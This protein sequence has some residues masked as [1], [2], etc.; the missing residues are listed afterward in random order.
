M[1]TVTSVVA[2]ETAL[3]PILFT[4]VR[5]PDPGGAQAYGLVSGGGVSTGVVVNGGVGYTSAPTVSILGDGVGAKAVAAI[6]A[7]AVTSVTIT[8]TGTGYTWCLIV[9]G[10]VLRLATHPF[11]TAEGG[12]QYGGYDWLG[13][14]MS[15]DIDA[16]QAMEENGIDRVP[17]V[18]LHLIDPDKYIWTNYE[19]N[20]SRGFKGAELQMDLAFFDRQ[21]ST[22]TTDYVTKFVGLCEPPEADTS[23]M[24]LVAATRNNTQQTFLPPVRISSRCPW[25]FPGD[26]ASQID[27]TNV[28]S[29]FYRCGYNPTGGSGTA[30][31]SDC[32]YTKT[33]CQSRGMF[34]I[35]RFGGITFAP[36]Q[37][38][39]GKSFLEGKY[40]EGVNSINDAKWSEPY[41]LLYG[42]TWVQPPVMNVLGDANSTR[43]EVVLCADQL[44][45]SGTTDPGSV[46]KVIVND[47]QIPFV[48]YSPDKNTFRW[49][50]VTNGKRNGSPCADKLYDSKGDPYGSLATIE[51]CVPRSLADSSSAPKVDVL[52]QGPQIHKFQGISSI[53]V[54]GGVGVATLVGTNLD[55]ASTDPTYTITISGNSNSALNGTWP[56]LNA[57]TSTTF[58]FTTTASNG[59]SSGG[60]VRYRIETDNPAWILADVLIKT[61][62]SWDEIDLQSFIDAAAIADTQINYLDSTGTPTNLD[63]DG[64]AHKRFRYSFSLRDRTSAAEVIR[65]IRAGFNAYLSWNNGRI[66][67]DIERSLGEQ[68]PAAI[69][70]SNNAS[71]ITSIAYDGSSKN[72]YSAYDFGPSSIKRDDQGNS[73]LRV[74]RSQSA[75]SP[76]KISFSFMDKENLWQQD[77][78]NEVE[79]DDVTRTTVEYEQTLNVRG[80]NT[81]DHCQRIAA[82]Y[83][84]KVHRGNPA[85][86]TRGTISVSFDTTFRAQHLRVGHIIR[87]TDAQHG[88]SNQMFRVRKISAT[89]NFE[90]MTIEASWHYDGWYQDAYGQVAQETL[91]SLRLDLTDRAPLVW[92]PNQTTPPANDPLYS[93]TERTFALAAVATEKDAAGNPVV[94]LSIVGKAPV[95]SFGTSRPPN[96]SNQATVASTGG[97]LTGNRSY[98]LAV[99]SVDSAGAYSAPSFLTRGDAVGAGSAF[100]QTVQLRTWDANAVSGVLFAGVDPRRMSWQADLTGTPSSATLTSLNDAYSGMPDL[101]A[102]KLRVKIR[103]VIH[104]G[105]FGAALTG[106]GN[107]TFTIAGAGWTT[108]QWAGYSCSVLG[109][110]AGG[111][112][113]VL[114]YSVVSNTATTLTLNRNPLTD[115]VAVGDVLCM[116]SKISVSGNTFSDANW[117]NSF[118]TGG[119]T[120]NA[121]VGNHYTVISGTGRGQSRLIT[122]NTSTSITTLPFATPLD[123]TSVGIVE[124]AA[125]DSSVDSP[126]ISNTSLTAQ[127]E[128]NPEVSNY[129]GCV[130]SVRVLTVA[131]DDT[132]SD[133]A[134]APMREIYLFGAIRSTVP[135]G[136]VTVSTTPYAVTGLED[137][138][139]LQ[140]GSSV[141]NLPALTLVLRHPIWLINASSSTVTLNAYSGD[142]VGGASSV[143]LDAGARFQ[144]LPNS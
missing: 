43:F 80:P 125:A 13:R 108:N 71:P 120:A 35:G 123:S 29:I 112:L 98:Y 124:S 141:V 55:I 138:I 52:I 72:G 27:S 26:V 5:F 76:N 104:S 53:T 103:R 30:G 28:D 39:R 114:N 99:C 59:T 3:Q 4:A 61:R 69:T 7:G 17:R 130:I 111:F 132:E 38:W 45:G 57:S 122:G 143:T 40:I 84:A 8:A 56:I 88:F 70:G 65:S 1:S 34:T 12:V 58:S 100:T 44:R 136:Q 54:T 96:I 140:T 81:F 115:G 42:A 77:V 68:Q 21:T 93:H 113:S 32:T 20:A 64:A 118:A 33:A 87:V 60:F 47:T 14:I 139:T 10:D 9:F 18:T 19:M 73:T 102:Q 78:L 85:G 121:E 62:F 41:P 90:G 25:I 49:E 105:P 116:R 89:T 31:F 128:L 74:S 110:V 106:V 48:P 22:F 67:V 75:N 51:I 107:P 79:P 94:V 95:N 91:G 142:T 131:A 6:A 15:Q 82:T 50:W 16:V 109:Q 11:N 92:C 66:R 134:L 137:V 129:V 24:T 36:P 144:L 101:L 119:L 127:I 2:N 86:D 97:S 46:Q 133:E 135:L 126:L 117:T 83:L 23:M 37:N 63:S